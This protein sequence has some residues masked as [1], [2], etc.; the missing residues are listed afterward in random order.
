MLIRLLQS[1]YYWLLP[2]LFW[3]GIVALSLMWN[4]SRLESA[5]QDIALERGSTM[6]QMVRQTKIN[7]ILM[8]SDPKIFKR[9]VMEEIGYRVVSP[10]PMQPEN[11]ADSWEARALSGFRKPGDFLFERQDSDGEV[12]YRYIGPV[13]MQENCL[14]CHGGEGVEVGDLRGGISV[15]V[16]ARPIFEAQTENL[17]L[18]LFT[19]FGGFLLLA[20]STTFLMRQLRK[21]WEMLIET[22][23]ELKHQE[24][25]FS[26]ITRNMGEG[27]VVVDKAGVMIFV[28]PECEWILGWD[29]EQMLGKSWLDLV[30]PKQDR[31]GTDAEKVLIETLNDGLLRREEGVNLLHKDGFLIP[32][33]YTVS[34]MSEGEE[35]TGA[36]ITYNDITERKRAEEERS[37]MERQLNQTHKMEAVGQLAGGIAHEIN[38]P[39]QYVEE[40]LRFLQESNVDIDTLLDAYH[41]LLQQ[42]EG[43]ESLRSQVEE[44]KRIIKDVDFDYLKDETPKTLEQTLEGA[45]QVARIVLAMKEFA[46]PGSHNMELV[47]LNKIIRNTVAVCRNEWKY[48]ADTELRLAEDLPQVECLG[49][50][51]SQV[52]LNLVVNAAH[53]IE[54]TKREGKGKITISSALRNGRMELRIADNGSGIPEAV[55]KSIFNPF[56]TTK[57]V[58]RGTGQGLAIAQDIV[59]DKHRG[60]LFFETEEGVGTTFIMQL[61]LAQREVQDAVT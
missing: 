28:N 35:I 25:F 14:P 46:H 11:M 1:R 8:Q 27:C 2:L 60:Q 51:I 52:V 13:F 57:E 39:I 31:D 7:P 53:A 34:A 38:T 3:F 54:A 4:L 40:N 19:H 23:D 21:H 16:N 42:A 12:R 33:S 56:F 41:T 20:G 15:S 24:A 30:L 29:A 18:V 50:E 47:D 36:V 61:P 17:E 22:R 32:V 5:V 59:A 6:F 37:R 10:L 9:Q 26:G 44:V 49:G 58:G 43:I 45:R 48:V 55:R